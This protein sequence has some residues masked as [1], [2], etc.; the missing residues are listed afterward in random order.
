[1]SD[2]ASKA[3]HDDLGRF[4]DALI[5]TAS[6]T[7][8]SERLIEKDYYC[9]VVLNDLAALYRQ[10]L[11]FKGGTC[12]SK[13]HTDFF[14]LSEDLDFAVSVKPDAGRGERRRLAEPFKA[15]LAGVAARLPIFSEAVALTG[16]NNN[17]QHN[18][19]L[20]YCSAVTGD[21]E[22]IKI[23]ISL[24]EEFL[25]PCGELPARTILIDP[26]TR[27]PAVA[28]VTVRA[29]A[30]PEAFAE[31]TRAALT[32][33][34]PAI[35]DL[36]DLDNAIRKGRLQHGTPEFRGLVAQKL[37]VTDDPVD[38]SPARLEAL[39]RQIETQ[40]KPVLRAADYEEFALD[41][42]VALLR[43][44]ASACQPKWPTV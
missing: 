28:P 43:E 1:M 38:L 13:V 6:E 17:K 16:Q 14:R 42:M 34:E 19:Q 7:G 30:L 18:G 29:I 15:H 25:L 3:Y 41:R 33:R 40:L 8:F 27:G 2:E 26:L 32:R 36:F 10:G 5:L 9:S 35:R 21:V 11:V 4:R 12:L 39:A 44:I 31:K 20:A 24:R 37:A 22:S 23:E